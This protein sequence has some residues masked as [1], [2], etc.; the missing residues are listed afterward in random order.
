MK[1]EGYDAAEI[2]RRAEELHIKPKD[3]RPLIADVRTDEAAAAKRLGKA[4]KTGDETIV[5]DKDKNPIGRIPTGRG[6]VV[7][8]AIEDANYTAA[9]KKLERLK[10]HIEENGERVFGPQATKDRQTLYDDAGIA[11]GIV[12]PLGKTDTALEHEFGTLGKSGAYTAQGANLEAIN[13]K[14]EEVKT[15][16]QMYRNQTLT[17]ITPEE[18]A[19]IDARG[20]G[21]A[22]GVPPK[23]EE[24]KP[25]PKA[26]GAPSRPEKND[27]LRGRLIHLRDDTSKPQD[28]RDG[29][30]AKLKELGF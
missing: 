13:R 12:S 18:L 8:F 2:Q 24:A 21:G 23:A 25:T 30:K 11:V 4:G 1:I 22:A 5:R 26:S 9:I 3:Y 14:I 28:I 15:N 16:Q 29:A 17:P 20:K 7:K 10:N 19:D 6:G 27:L